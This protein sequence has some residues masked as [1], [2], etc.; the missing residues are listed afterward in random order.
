MDTQDT[1]LIEVS[2]QN[3]IFEF[4]SVIPGDY[5]LYAWTEIQPGAHTDPDFMKPF[6]ELGRMVHVGSSAKVRVDVKL[7]E[8]GKVSSRN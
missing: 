8:S 7:V 3:G 2:D 1:H 4:S 5:R 6:E